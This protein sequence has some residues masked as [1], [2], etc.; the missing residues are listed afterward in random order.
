MAYLIFSTDGQEWDRRELTKPVVLGRSA[1][2]DIS[3]HDILLSR[4]HCRLT[5]VD[6]NWLLIDLG[7]RNGTVVGDKTVEEHNLK[8]GEAIRIGKTK[9]TFKADAFVPPRAKP[10]RPLLPPLV[11]RL[12]D[13][14][15]G[16][17]FELQFD[18]LPP[19]PPAR[20]PKTNRQP[21]PRPRPKD[22]ESFESEDLYAML[23][24]IAS[25]SWDSIYAVNAQPLRK[26]RLIPQ[27]NI[28]GQPK[29]RPARPQVSLALQAEI[30][31][32]DRTPSAQSTASVQTAT[33]TAPLEQKPRRAVRRIDPAP[34]RHRFARLS[35][36]ISRVGVMRIF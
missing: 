9:V 29:L 5:P 22:P 7:S 21:S 23:E 1:E 8:H 26:S 12:D 32:E 31:S 6:G 34:I 27:P 16:T 11:G 13:T 28:A 15:A 2:C 30:Q 18:P 10:N 36:W 20:P 3:I 24:Q 4:R 14:I 19:A 33:L 25:S 17:V 35:R